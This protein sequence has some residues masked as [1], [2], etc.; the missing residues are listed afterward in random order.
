LGARRRGAGPVAA[1]PPLLGPP[2]APQ[3]CPLARAPATAAEPLAGQPPSVLAPPILYGTSL[4]PRM[5]PQRLEAPRAGAALPLGLFPGAGAVLPGPRPPLCWPLRQTL[6]WVASRLQPFA[7]GPLHTSA[8]STFRGP[9]PLLSRTLPAAA[10][11]PRPPA[12]ARE[13]RA[14]PP[15]PARTKGRGAQ[16][17]GR[18]GRAVFAPAPSPRP[19]VKPR[20]PPQARTAIIP[21]PRAALTTEL[22]LLAFF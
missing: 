10:R 21:P 12:R 7:C 6:P 13:R 14:N 8:A 15:L 22:L 2:S 9:L 4:Q 1:T 3:A 20:T 18:P 11:C 19:A 17:M 16:P 5:Q